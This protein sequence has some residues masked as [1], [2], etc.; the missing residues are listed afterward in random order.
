MQHLNKIS[1]EAQLS[2][3]PLLKNIISSFAFYQSGKEMTLI[4]DVSNQ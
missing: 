3:L 1:H 4:L 2:I